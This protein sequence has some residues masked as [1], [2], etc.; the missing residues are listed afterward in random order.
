[1]SQSD[2]ADDRRAAPRV[3]IELRVE[4][5]RLNS[6]FSDYTKNISKG[7]SFIRTDRPLP[8]GTEFVFCLVIPKMHEPLRLLGK[9]VWII[10]PEQGTED[11]PAGMGIEFQYR[12]DKE[13]SDVE[14][15]VTKVMIDEL[16][17]EITHGLLGHGSN[18]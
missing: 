7:G 13:R 10:T 5:K 2:A 8:M 12:D 3:P 16:G 17:S 4:Y 1:M 9:V 11:K 6:F 18:S 15:W 14:G